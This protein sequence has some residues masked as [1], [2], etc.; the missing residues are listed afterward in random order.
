MASKL[1]NIKDTVTDVAK[2]IK[3]DYDTLDRMF[4]D[5]QTIEKNSPNTQY[6][7]NHN[8]YDLLGSALLKTITSGKF[9]ETESRQM[10]EE[11]IDLGVNID[12]KNDY[13]LNLS[14]SPSSRGGRDFKAKITKD[15]Y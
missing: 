2:G 1:K 10:I 15:I 12:L 7:F 3:N 14:T 11:F 8:L 9:N 13:G 6:R 4:S 5:S